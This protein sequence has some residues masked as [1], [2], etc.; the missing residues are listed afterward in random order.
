MELDFTASVPTWTGIAFWPPRTTLRVAPL[1]A[2]VGHHI[3]PLVALTSPTGITSSKVSPV[4]ATSVHDQ[5][6]SPSPLRG[7]TPSKDLE[8]VPIIKKGAEMNEKNS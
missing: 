2:P 7:P 6:P 1:G 4:R 3:A 5:L 8:K